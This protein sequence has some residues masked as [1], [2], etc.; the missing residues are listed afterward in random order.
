MGG[1]LVFMVKSG[2]DKK[3]FKL[4]MALKSPDRVESAKA[5]E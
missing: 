2:R 5:A 4:R 1:I 3:M